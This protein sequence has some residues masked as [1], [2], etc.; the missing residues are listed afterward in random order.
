MTTQKELA[1]AKGFWPLLRNG[2]KTQTRRLIGK[3]RYQE[4]DLVL[5]KPAGSAESSPCIELR[6]IR[7]QIERLQSIQ[8]KDLKAEGFVSYA[9]Y[10][11]FFCQQYGEELWDSNPKVWVLS[12]KAARV[13][14]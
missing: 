14:P 12:F 10:K 6:I 4:G 1:F 11:A 2:Q 13:N 3:G 5:A 9:S 7:V 8:L